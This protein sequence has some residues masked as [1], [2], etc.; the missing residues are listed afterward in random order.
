VANYFYNMIIGENQRVVIGMIDGFDIDYYEKTPMPVMK[1][2]AANGF[3]KRGEAIFPTLTNAN[4]ISIACGAWPDE[5]GVTTNCYFDEVTGTAKFLESSEFI[6]A[7][8]IFARAAKHGINSALLTCKSKTAKIIGKE[9]TIAITA[10]EPDREIVEQ[11]GQPP[12]MYSSE[13]NYWLW[14]VAIDI[15]R[16]QPEIRMLYIH[17]TDYPMHMWAPEESESQ[18]HMS[19]LDALLGETRKVAP[20]AVMIITADHGMNPK[21]RCW[22]LARACKARGLELKFAVSPVADRLLKHHRGFGGVSYVY[23][24]RYTE[25]LQAIGT[26]MN[27]EGVEDVLTREEAASRFHLMPE[28][29][30]DLV[31]IPDRD[32]VFG[33]LEEEFEVLDPNYR[34]HGS[35][36][37]KDIPLLIYDAKG[38]MPPPEEFQKNLDLT[39]MLYR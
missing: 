18:K 19:K 13:I 15:L 10:E 14:E 23:L 25:M 17:T 36:Y 11:Y 16:N 24:H 1:E 33:D 34:S 30:G 6:L 39:R 7:P 20:D 22:D 27:I 31:V 5:H 35:L 32:T 38:E 37:E 29:I 28:R 26:I 4:N 8:T 3:F 9:A 2:M 21:M 12:I